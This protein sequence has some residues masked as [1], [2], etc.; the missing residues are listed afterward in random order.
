MLSLQASSG[1]DPVLIQKSILDFCID[2]VDAEAEAERI[3]HI[4]I[5]AGGFIVGPNL[6]LADLASLSSTRAAD[7]SGRPGK[8]S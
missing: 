1:S 5:H 8:L 3:N 4:G 6:C 2:G 7:G